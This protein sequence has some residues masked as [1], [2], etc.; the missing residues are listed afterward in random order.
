MALKTILKKLAQGRDWAHCGRTWLGH[1]L[2][3]D[4]KVLPIPKDPNDEKNVLLEIRAGTG[5]D[6]AALFAAE[7]FRMYSRYAERAALE[8]RRHLR[9]RAP[10]RA[11]SRKSSP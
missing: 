10:A 9:E 2:R 8:G 5:G 6:E 11:A 7:V 4:L 1:C 3:A